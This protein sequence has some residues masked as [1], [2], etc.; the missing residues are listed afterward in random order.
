MQVQPQRQTRG[1]EATA[2][3]AVLVVSEL[4]EVWSGGS[5]QALGEASG[6]AGGKK[7]HSAL[8]QMRKCCHSP[9]MSS[10]GGAFE[11]WS[12]IYGTQHRRQIA[13]R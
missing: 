8:A 1:A 13:I 2:M 12:I 4:K 3:R 9:R 6:E 11:E 10:A 7:H 5:G